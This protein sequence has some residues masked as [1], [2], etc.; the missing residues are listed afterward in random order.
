[1]DGF[2]GLTGG[3]LQMIVVVSNCKRG[4]GFQKL[5]VPSVG[6]TVSI[7]TKKGMMR[8]REGSS[9][10][11]VF[12]NDGYNKTTDITPTGLNEKRNG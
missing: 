4:L 8:L 6:G 12:G 10:Q 9:V 7:F 3:V 5:V 1:M 2:I 11:Q